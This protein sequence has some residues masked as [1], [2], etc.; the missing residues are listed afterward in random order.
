MGTRKAQN[1]AKKLLRD[2]DISASPPID[3][4]AIAQRLDLSLVERSRLHHPSHGDVSGLLLR[5]GGMAIC[6][7]NADQH[8]NRRRFTVAHELGHF[9]LHPPQESYVDPR[10][11]VAARSNRATEG[12]DLYEIEAN[13]FAAELLMPEEWIRASVKGP[14]DVFNDDTIQTLAD[15]YVVS[16]QAMTYRLINLGLLP[17]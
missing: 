3:V 5:K 7:V 4:R 6:V 14:L 12:A 17:G 8:E 1:R 10:F 9:L 13:A 2:F 11:D 15:E 16:H